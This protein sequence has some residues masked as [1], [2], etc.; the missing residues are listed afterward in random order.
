[1]DSLP[2]FDPG[3]DPLERNPASLLVVPTLSLL[4]GQTAVSLSFRVAVISSI[5]ILMASACAWLLGKRKW[6]LLF[7][8]S[9]VAFITGYGMHQRLLTPQFPDHHLRLLTDGRKA[10]QVEGFFYREPETRFGWS[11][12]YLRAE[13]IWRPLGARK[14]VGNVLITVRK[15]QR[16]WHYG[17]RVRLRVRVRPPRP[18]RNP[19]EFDYRAY[20]ARREIYLTGFLGDD[21]GVELLHRDNRGVWKWMQHVRGEIQGFTD[22]NLPPR[23]AGLLKALV[24]GDRG[25]L[26]RETRESFAAAGVAHVLSIS[27]LHVGMLGLVAFI[28]VRFLGSLSSTLMLRWNLFK[29]A[30]FLSFIVVLFYAALAGGR[31]PT[32]RAAIMVGVYVLA[33]LFDREEE[34]YI[35]LALAALLIG[36]I[37]PGVVMDTSFQ[38]SFLAV[39]F[40]VWGLR[41]IQQLRELKPKDNLLQ[42]QTQNW[43][44]RRVPQIALYLAVPVL[45]TLGT[46]PV[47]TYHFGRLSLAG[48]LANPI[49]VPIV[50]WVLVPL[51]FLIGFL[52]L[53]STALA[54]PLLW[55]AKPLLSLTL[56][57][58]ELFSELPMG[59]IT[60]P[61]PNLLEL[62]IV[63]LAIC[64][65][66]VL[67]RRTHVYVLLVF[68]IVA[69]AADG[70]YWW[71]QRW[72]RRDLRITYLSV[73]HGD[74]AVVEFPD[75]RVLL[76]DAGGSSF[77]QYDPGR[78]IVAPF[79]RSRRIAKVDY[80][81]VSHPRIDHYGGMKSILEEFAP[82][83]F[84]SG[85]VGGGTRRYVELEEAA[86]HLGVRRVLLNQSDSCRDIGKVRICV[87]Y[88]SD[89]GGEESS[90]VMRLSLGR[91][92]FLFPGDINKQDEERLVGLK[93]ELA[94]QVLK[95][96]RHGSLTANTKSFVGAVAPSLAIFSMGYRSPRAE[97]IARYDDAGS[98]VLRTDEDGAIIV[99]TNGNRLSYTTHLSGKRGK[100]PL[101][102]EVN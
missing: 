25:G 91:Y 58:V 71:R 37:W 15:V 95:V 2:S 4:L 69:M 6:A 94:S 22:R 5:A 67:Q 36:L 45:A 1:M 77:P 81:L 23:E 99:E 85:P 70:A 60:V 7:F 65:I 79:L 39:L 72:G 80:V 16:K 63:Y 101:S 97:V 35:S 28:V 9:G 50:G 48:F 59:V 44:R 38:L 64:S 34:F 56:W 33:V 61:K 27:G 31:I 13:Y 84:W 73:G 78:S 26:S 62:G 98:E 21:G 40:I 51:G 8:F 96:P 46:G 12:W 87:L 41:R 83:E 24:I 43:L 92:H 54:L 75:S 11:R 86:R 42:F 18:A 100:I 49:L 14:A 102:M 3:K 93:T 68:L 32:I 53:F 82:S 19:G 90:V 76:I 29:I 66:L 89:A 17:D 74:A 10:V 20:L 30:T 47:V 57:M 55:I 52:C 88:P